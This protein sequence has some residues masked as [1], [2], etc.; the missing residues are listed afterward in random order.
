MCVHV[1]IHVCN[2]G[3]AFGFLWFELPVMIIAIVIY[4]GG[5]G[6]RL[7]GGIILTLQG[8]TAFLRFDPCAL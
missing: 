7:G 4:L 5:G 8:H 6:G 1:H 2:V 3:L